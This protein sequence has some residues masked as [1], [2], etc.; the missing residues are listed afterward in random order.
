M[1]KRRVRLF[2]DGIEV[3]RMVGAAPP[4]ETTYLGVSGAS[5]TP[6]LNTKH[7]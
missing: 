6:F 5:N 1:P 7:P 4:Q 2:D 3:A